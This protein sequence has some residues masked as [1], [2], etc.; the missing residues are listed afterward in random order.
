VTLYVKHLQDYLRQ[1]ESG[2]I[3]DK[4]TADRLYSTRNRHIRDMQLWLGQEHLD[5]TLPDAAKVK[6]VYASTAHIKPVKQL[7]E[8]VEKQ[9]REVVVTDV[10]ITGDYKTKHSFKRLFNAGTGELMYLRDEQALHG[11]KEGFLDEDL[12][13][14]DRAR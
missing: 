8:A 9:D 6:E 2:K 3:T 1:V 4:T 13:T 14:V 12:K 10:V 7:L 11:K 5:K